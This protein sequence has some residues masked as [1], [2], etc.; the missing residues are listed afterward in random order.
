MVL[1]GEVHVVFNIT[2]PPNQPAGRIG[3]LLSVFAN[4]GG[5]F[6]EKTMNQSIALLAI[7]IGLLIA[8]W[9]DGQDA[10]LMEKPLVVACVKCQP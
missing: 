5:A 2:K 3:Y 8:G 6:E 1:T 9:M 10:N 7:T 4:L